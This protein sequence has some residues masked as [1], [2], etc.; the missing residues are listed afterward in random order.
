MICPRCGKSDPYHI[1]RKTRTKNRVRSLYKCRGCRRQFTVTIGT[2][3]EGSKVP[4]RKW[5]AAIFL[6]CAFRRGTGAQQ[7]HIQTGV[8]YKSASFMCKRIREAMMEAM[9]EDI[10]LRETQS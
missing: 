9:G 10:L 4:L 5:F 8:T 2:I 6:M 1:K 3:F 7:V